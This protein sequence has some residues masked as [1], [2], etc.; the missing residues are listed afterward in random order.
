[1]RSRILVIM[2]EKGTESPRY[3]DAWSYTTLQRSPK[4]VTSPGTLDT[5]LNSLQGYLPTYSQEAE[6]QPIAR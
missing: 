5:S 3:S 6:N 1:M 2:V 4:E